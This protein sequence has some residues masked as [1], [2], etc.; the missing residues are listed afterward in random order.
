[1]LRRTL[2]DSFGRSPYTFQLISEKRSP[3]SGLLLPQVLKGGRPPFGRRNIIGLELAWSSNLTS[4]R[5][6]AREN[7]QDFNPFAGL[8]TYIGPSLC[9]SSPNPAVLRVHVI[10]HIPIPW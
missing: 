4:L 3:T 8:V 2:S 6:R 5:Y 7:V 10:G 1:M 9:S